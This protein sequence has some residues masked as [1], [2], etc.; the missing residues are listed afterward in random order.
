MRKVLGG[1]MRQIGIIAAAGLVAM[2]KMIDRLADDHRRAYQI[3]KGK[4]K[5][6]NIL[7]YIVHNVYYICII[8]I[9]L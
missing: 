7:S 1:G 5:L 8:I 9:Y 4:Q 6:T 2:D 3:G